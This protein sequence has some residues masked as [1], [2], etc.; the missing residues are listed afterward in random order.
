MET[1][2]MWSGHSHLHQIFSKFFITKII[3]IGSFLMTD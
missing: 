2:F 1:F 3:K